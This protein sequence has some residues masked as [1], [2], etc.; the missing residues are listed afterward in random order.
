M[1]K[2]WR[3]RKAYMPRSGDALGTMEGPKSKRPRCDCDLLMGERMGPVT[4]Q[5][6]APVPREAV[7]VSLVLL[8]V[9]VGF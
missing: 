4:V 8:E 7:R 6:L 9:A 3:E 2:R 1:T 5:R